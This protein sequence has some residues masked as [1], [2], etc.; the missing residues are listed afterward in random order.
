MLFKFNCVRTQLENNFQMKSN[1]FRLCVE[2]TSREWDRKW[3]TRSGFSFAKARIQSTQTHK[4][5]DTN[6][7]IVARA[8]KPLQSFSFSFLLISFHFASFFG[9]CRCGCCFISRIVKWDGE[10]DRESLENIQFYSKEQANWCFTQRRRI[11]IRIETR[12]EQNTLLKH[13]H[14]L[15]IFQING[16][17]EIKQISAFHVELLG[18]RIYAMP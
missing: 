7:R 15:K 14:K 6:E 13:Q 12:R 2:R 9:C 10:R 11:R 5:T 1:W 3:C 16:A 4:K 18:T 8:V 17:D